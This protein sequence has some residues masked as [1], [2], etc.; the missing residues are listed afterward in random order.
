MSFFIARRQLFYT[1][2]KL[3][4]ARKL[5]GCV[6]FKTEFLKHCILLKFFVKTIFR[7]ERIVSFLS[8]VSCFNE[9]RYIHNDN[10]SSSNCSKLN[11]KNVNV[12]Y[13]FSIRQKNNLTQLA[14]QYI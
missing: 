6:I 3:T 9:R 4:I 8:V 13:L 7:N 5:R 2:I 14:L 10:S 12:I 11:N 1:K